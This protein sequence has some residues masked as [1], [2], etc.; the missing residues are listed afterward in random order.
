MQLIKCYNNEILKLVNELGGGPRRYCRE[1]LKKFN[2]IVAEIYSPP[3]VT[4]AAKMLPSLRMCPGFALDLVTAYE[5]G[6]PWEFSDKQ[7]R[8]DCRKM[9]LEQEPVLVVG[10]SM[11]TAFRT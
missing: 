11:C 3:R 10:S 1:R 9:V 4:E 5:M 8:D 2:R 6:R 7:C